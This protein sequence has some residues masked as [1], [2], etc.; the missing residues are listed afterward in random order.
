MMVQERLKSLLDG[1]CSMSKMGRRDAL[2]M[3]SKIAVGASTVSLLSGLLGYLLGSSTR[4]EAT[5]TL[6]ETRYE[7]VTQTEITIETTTETITKT[8]TTTQITTRTEKPTIAIQARVGKSYDYDARDYEVS[9]RVT[10]PELDDLNAYYE[11]ASIKGKLDKPLWIREEDGYSSTFLT[12]GEIGEQRINLEVEKDGAKARKNLSINIGLSEEEISSALLSREDLKILWSDLLEDVKL[13]IDREDIFRKE[14]E[15]VNVAKISKISKPSSIYLKRLASYL[16]SSRVDY[17][18]ILKGVSLLVPTINSRPW[19]CYGSLTEDLNKA[20]FLLNGSQAYWL[21]KFLSEVDVDEAH[22]YAARA[23]T[24]QMLFI[25][26]DW[27]KIEPLDTFEYDGKKLQLFD[28]VKQLCKKH[29]ELEAEGKRESLRDVDLLKRWSD[30]SELNNRHVYYGLR[31]VQLAPALLVVDPVSR[32]YAWE[33]D[34]NFLVIGGRPNGLNVTS[35]Y[36]NKALNILS[37]WIENYEEL[38]N[39]LNEILNNPNKK[40]KWGKTECSLVERIWYYT[41]INYP[42][43]REYFPNS[44]IEARK[45]S[46]DTLLFKGSRESKNSIVLYGYSLLTF[47]SP[48]WLEEVRVELASCYGNVVGYPIYREE[49]NYPQ[50]KKPGWCHGEPSFILNETDENLLYERSGNELLIDKEYTYTI[51]F[52]VTRKDAARKDGIKYLYIRLPL[53]LKLLKW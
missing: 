18:E 25:S 47:N 53:F 16:L 45:D 37:K 27:L 39:E 38:N 4:K 52:L 7:T 40:I 24:D 44:T 11:N 41:N 1:L 22:F 10:S 9:L 50:D 21:A 51:N 5:R 20:E 28:L 15:I 30:R 23:K 17:E 19:I 13:S 2:S 29:F 49:F 8:L 48:K 42:W 31:Q 34:V 14:Y 6:T 35:P 46:Y 33:D 43:N 32:R 36:P 12:K 3:F 26:S